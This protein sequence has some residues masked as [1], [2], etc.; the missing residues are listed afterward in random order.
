MQRV[1]K[2]GSL[3]FMI[4]F[5]TICFWFFHVCVQCLC[6]SDKVFSVIDCFSVPRYTYRQDRKK[7][8]QYVLL[9]SQERSGSVVEYLTRD[10]GATGSSLTGGTALW[11]LSKTHFKCVFFPS[12]V[13]VQLKRRKESN[14]TKQIFNFYTSA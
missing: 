3:Q 5:Y 8:I 7:F 2:Q 13:L 10:R 1:T 11:S 6:F 12:L 4:D 9:S 14:Q